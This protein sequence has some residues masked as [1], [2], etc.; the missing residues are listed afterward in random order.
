MNKTLIEISN[1]F[2]VYDR[3]LLLVHTNIFRCAAYGKN[4]LTV[5]EIRCIGS[6][7]ECLDD[8]FVLKVKEL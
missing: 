6:F 4:W 1:I 7:M 3:K 2:K 5:V 8:V